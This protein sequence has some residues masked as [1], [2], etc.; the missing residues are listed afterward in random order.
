MA[1]ERWKLT[2]HDDVVMGDI[3]QT[4]IDEGKIDE[5]RGLTELIIN[6]CAIKM[7]MTLDEFFEMT[8]EQL[9]KE[10]KKP[11]TPQGYSNFAWGPAV[12]DR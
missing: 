9:I 7:D 8:R 4:L 12:L 6:Q 3:I 11:P 10:L 1:L 5:A 2:T